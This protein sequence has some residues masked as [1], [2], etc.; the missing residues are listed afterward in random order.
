MDK[1]INITN[2]YRIYINILILILIIY[3]YSRYKVICIH[4]DI[5]INYIYIGEFYIMIY[6]H[7]Y[8]L[9]ISI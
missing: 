8:M 4:I 5:G 3:Y 1:Y 6:Y 7:N 9:L 2:I